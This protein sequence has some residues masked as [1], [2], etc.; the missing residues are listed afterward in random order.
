LYDNVAQAGKNYIATFNGSQ[1]S[2]GVY[3]YSLESNN[4]RIVKKMLMLK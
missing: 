2:S 3:F 1:C 4:Q